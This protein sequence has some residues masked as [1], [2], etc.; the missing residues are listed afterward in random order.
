MKTDSVSKFTKETLSFLSRFKPKSLSEDNWNKFCRIYR[1]RTTKEIISSGYFMGCY[2]PALIFY[3][4][5]KAKNIPARFMEMISSKSQLFIS[6]NNKKE[7]ENIRSHCFVELKN[8]S[9]TIIVDPA[10]RNII[11]KYPSEFLFFSGNPYK[12]KSFNGF[13]KAQKLFIIKNF[14]AIKGKIFIKK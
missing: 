8:H 7:I 10:K 14:K 4:K 11:S 5:A 2:E 12:W 3:E 13:Y 9:R 1:K 6:D